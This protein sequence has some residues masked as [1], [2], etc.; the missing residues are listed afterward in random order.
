MFNF[1]SIEK[2]EDITNN[3]VIGVLTASLGCALGALSMSRRVIARLEQEKLQLWV[4]KMDLL[5]D[6][7][8]LQRKL[9]D[10]E[11]ESLKESN[12]DLLKE[13]QLLEEQAT[14]QSTAQ[15]QNQET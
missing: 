8:T 12:A 2:G 4:D 9:M 7:M 10:R 1:S 6:K 3:L 13:V 14:S 11:I 15:D 5:K